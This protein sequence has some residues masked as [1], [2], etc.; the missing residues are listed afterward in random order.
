MVSG[1]GRSL[2]KLKRARQWGQGTTANIQLE[3]AGF[4]DASFMVVKKT[5]LLSRQSKLDDLCLARSE[6]NSAKALQL[7]HRPDEAGRDVTH[8]KLNH[9]VRGHLAR[10]SQWCP[11]GKNFSRAESRRR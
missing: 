5:Q 9:L 6:A 2:D 8:V 4:Q 7:A 11:D 3:L 10:I 1:I